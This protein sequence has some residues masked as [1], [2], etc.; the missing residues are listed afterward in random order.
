MTVFC[1]VCGE[2]FKNN[3]SLIRHRRC[4]SRNCGLFRIQHC[5]LSGSLISYLS[6]NS[7]FKI[8]ECIKCGK[9]FFSLKHLLIHSR[10]HTKSTPYKCDFCSKT[11]ML[12]VHLYYHLNSHREENININ[13]CVKCN[14]ETRELVR[15]FGFAASTVSSLICLF[16]QKRRF[17]NIFQFTLHLRT[18]CPQTTVCS[19]CGR[20]SVCPQDI[21]SFLQNQAPLKRIRGRR[22]HSANVNAAKII[23]CESCGRTFQKLQLLEL[24][25][26]SHISD[27]L[28]CC[29][30]CQEVFRNSR[31]YM[32]HMKNCL[33]RKTLPS[34]DTF[35]VDHSTVINEENFG[36]PYCKL[37]FSSPSQ[38]QTH[39]PLHSSIKESKSDTESADDDFIAKYETEMIYSP[40]Y[41]HTLLC[42]KCGQVFREKE[43]L[44]VHIKTECAPDY[45]C[46]NCFKVFDQ[47][48][49][50]EKH[51]KNHNCVN[52]QPQPT[53]Y[54]VQHISSKPFHSSSKC[55]KSVIS[56]DSHTKLHLDE[57]LP[58][59]GKDPEKISNNFSSN[60]FDPA[61]RLKN[62]EKEMSDGD[63]YKSLPSDGRSLCD[64]CGEVFFALV[65]LNSHMK[66]H[67]CEEVCAPIY[68]TANMNNSRQSDIYPNQSP[69]LIF[70]PPGRMS[71][72]C[73]L[74]NSR[75]DNIF[76]SGP[77][78][79]S[80]FARI[81]TMTPV[82]QSNS[83]SN[84]QTNNISVPT[85]TS[86][87]STFPFLPSVDEIKNVPCP[88]L[89]S[90]GFPFHVQN[91]RGSFFPISNFDNQ[92]SSSSLSYGDCRN[93]LPLFPYNSSRF[94]VFYS[95]PAQEDDAQSNDRDKNIN[96]ERN[97]PISTFINE[98]KDKIPS[99]LML[100]TQNM[101][102]ETVPQ[103]INTNIPTSNHQNNNTVFITDKESLVSNLSPESNLDT[104]LT[105]SRSFKVSFSE[106]KSEN[107]SSKS[108]NNIAESDSSV[109]V[110]A[111]ANMENQNL[112]CP[113]NKLLMTLPNLSQDPNPPGVVLPEIEPLNLCQARNLEVGKFYN[114]P[115]D[116]ESKAFF[117][118]QTSLNNLHDNMQAAYVQPFWDESKS[119]YEMNF[120]VGNQCPTSE[121]EGAL[122]SSP[123]FQTNSI[124]HPLWGEP[125]AYYS[126]NQGPFRDQNYDDVDGGVSKMNVSRSYFPG[127]FENRN[128]GINSLYGYQNRQ[129]ENEST[130]PESRSLEY[131]PFLRLKPTFSNSVNNTI[132]GVGSS[133]DGDVKDARYQDS[134]LTA[135][136]DAGV[137]LMQSPNVFTSN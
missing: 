60:Y 110:E 113:V 44:E 133:K 24:H 23:Q 19:D 81:G 54:Q 117:P 89:V 43:K 70:P 94:N 109:P 118:Q 91:N 124:Q 28:F 86:S 22:Y 47:W 49:D 50:L 30:N 76:P 8:F 25:L 12:M 125:K 135:E 18:H 32:M 14:G 59:S 45:T 111:N 16:C 11:F 114:Y 37:S 29:R 105:N 40:N 121:N 85:F 127:F 120:N 122:K 51:I 116:L 17:S 21:I 112:E 128:S 95:V 78:M 57:A 132:Y 97:G 42:P 7:V 106:A 1:K 74:P 73:Y 15:K 79:N 98:N 134:T 3:V 136:R 99:P 35:V 130:N 102:L 104:N 129:T 115:V 46:K 33:R 9:T 126:M 84:I 62:L 96:H 75:T 61:N 80:N 48:S 101:N 123:R 55:Y 26:L 92:L 107:F 77:D 69:L 119:Y 52:E 72:P 82:T 39:L 63:N 41:I 64:V 31:V 10:I 6:K 131:M 27:P 65:E 87:A 38:L 68:T 36:C 137:E 66:I 53:E 100:A 83:F 4:K 58:S 103:K 93:K 5:C 13:K 67:D 56:H 108:Q 88:N 34:S 2:I 20:I 71:T 90:P